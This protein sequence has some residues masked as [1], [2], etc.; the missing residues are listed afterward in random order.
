ME[1][2]SQEQMMRIPV[3]PCL[4]VFWWEV[5]DQRGRVLAITA[6]D[7]AQHDS[8]VKGLSS[9]NLAVMAAKVLVLARHPDV[10]LPLL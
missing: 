3:E 2:C 4:V 5:G 10:A 1:L 7:V 6:V 9:S 8:L